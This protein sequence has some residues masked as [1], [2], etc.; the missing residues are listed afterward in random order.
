MEIF[1]NNSAFDIDIILEGVLNNLKVTGKLRYGKTFTANRQRV[2][3][4]QVTPLFLREIE[5]KKLKKLLNDKP[6][7]EPLSESLARWTTMNQALYCVGLMFK[8][9]YSKENIFQLKQRAIDYLEK[10]TFNLT[11]VSLVNYRNKAVLVEIGGA[12]YRRNRMLLESQ[13]PT[14]TK[15][16]GVDTSYGQLILR[17]AHHFLHATDY[18]RYKSYL[19]MGSPAYY[20]PHMKPVLAVMEANCPRCVLDKQVDTLSRTGPTYPHRLAPVHIFQFSTADICG[21][22]W[23]YQNKSRY[24]LYIS[25]L[26][27]DTSQSCHLFPMLN[28]SGVAISQ[29][30]R[31]LSNLY[32]PIRV[33]SSDFGVQYLSLKKESAA[34]EAKRGLESLRSLTRQNKQEQDEAESGE[35]D[36]QLI[37]KEIK[38]LQFSASRDGYIVNLSSPYNHQRSGA[39]E[40]LVKLIKRLMA[41]EYK[42]KLSYLDWLMLCSNYTA[43]LNARPIC[44]KSDSVISRQ[45]FLGL[46]NTNFPLHEGE[47]Q[48]NTSRAFQH[49]VEAVQEATRELFQELFTI[50]LDHYQRLAS[51]FGSQ[52]EIHLGDLVCIKSLLNKCKNYSV[53]IVEKLLDSTDG[54]VRDVVVLCMRPC[55]RHPQPYGEVTTTARLFKRHVRDLLLL[56]RREWRDDISLDPDIPPARD[57]YKN[58]TNSVVG[59]DNTNTTNAAGNITTTATTTTGNITNSTNATT[60]TT[61]ATGTRHGAS[62]WAG[63][64]VPMR[65]AGVKCKDPAR[66]FKWGIGSPE[67]SGDRPQ[68][69]PTPQMAREEAEKNKTNKYIQRLPGQKIG[70]APWWSHRPQEKDY[71]PTKTPEQLAKDLAE[72]TH[73]P[74]DT[75]TG[76]GN[77]IHSP[78]LQDPT[79]PREEAPGGRSTGGISEAI[80]GTPYA[81]L[82]GHN[83][84]PGTE[85]G[86]A[87]GKD[88]DR[89]PPRGG[90]D[91]PPASSSREPAPHPPDPVLRGLHGPDVGAQNEDNP[92]I[93]TGPPEGR[94]YNLRKKRVS[95]HNLATILATMSTILAIS[96][97]GTN[98]IRLPQ[99]L[100]TVTIGTDAIFN[101]IGLVQDSIREWN[102]S[103]TV[104]PRNSLGTY[105]GAQ[106]VNSAG[107]TVLD[108]IEK[109]TIF[110]GTNAEFYL[111]AE[112]EQL[113][114]IMKKNGFNTIFIRL[115]LIR[116]HPHYTASRFPLPTSGPDVI[117]SYMIN[118]NYSGAVLFKLLDANNLPIFEVVN[119]Y[120]KKL[121]KDMFAPCK[122]LVGPFTTLTKSF[123]IEAQAQLSTILKE[124]PTFESLKDSISAWKQPETNQ[125]CLYPVQVALP[126]Q[127]KFLDYYK[128]QDELN[129][130]RGLSLTIIRFGTFT[131]KI[132]DFKRNL[133]DQINY[134]N[135]E[136][137]VSGRV[138]ISGH[139]IG[140]FRQ[141]TL[142]FNI[143][144]YLIVA[145]TL[146]TTFLL[147]T[148]GCCLRQRCCCRRDRRPQWLRPLRRLRMFCC[149]TLPDRPP[150]YQDYEQYQP[151]VAQYLPMRPLRPA[152][153][154]PALLGPS[155]PALLGPSQPR[156][157]ITYAGSPV[158]D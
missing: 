62:G 128:F 76:E 54:V 27:C 84:G 7:Q 150:A 156:L 37:A 1:E 158:D 5:Q 19:A 116:N 66:V 157:A 30:V 82:C 133:T 47:E 148:I 11:K 109:C 67:A 26:T 52:P 124:D 151:P 93:T 141:I 129:N 45:S 119:T 102:R 6:Q 137:N 144:T 43:L 104:V 33:L 91:V 2:Q 21:P 60:T 114:E 107:K 65:P 57:E 63:S 83:A 145:N 113:R 58:S 50:R 9:K 48:G 121:P 46:S 16:I 152:P 132:K 71:F 97:P 88:Q 120:P 42:S 38:A 105:Q 13:I 81:G 87:K 64:K 139:L 125:T 123:R 53:G 36:S 92:E 74:P 3:D 70:L 39:A 61:A 29:H 73:L 18:R 44:V 101:D 118:A 130:E 68:H 25:I 94:R 75:N 149:Q 110:G 131:Q 4:S 147:I 89:H 146:G 15:V 143:I 31:Y 79:A 10:C 35:S 127:T 90:P 17:D 155:R 59:K 126:L 51:K 8:W 134:I 103:L 115:E 85:M 136:Y 49:N 24:K 72:K 80:E 20:V 77:E 154:P 96:T 142:G 56:A 12:V 135:S 86:P 100:C 41:R 112:L 78:P 28:Y 69:A 40:G 108:T 14:Y 22:F 111:N 122:L 117:R 140:Y 34:M 95:Y 99:D 23:Y 55:G 98:G 32:S 138:I 106:I 153:Q